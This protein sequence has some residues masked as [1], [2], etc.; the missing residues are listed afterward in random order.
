MRFQYTVEVEV[1]REGGGLF[2]SRDSL[3]AEIASAI[4]GADP[5][6]VSGDNGTEYTVTSWTVAEA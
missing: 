2:E 1:E 5:G 3:G 4:E 6:T